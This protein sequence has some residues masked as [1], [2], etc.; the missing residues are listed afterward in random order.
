MASGG[1]DHC[2]KL[3]DIGR[4]ACVSTLRGQSDSVNAVHF[5]SFSNSLLSASADKTLSHWD[6]R[7]VCSPS[8]HLTSSA[9]SPHTNRDYVYRHILATRAPAMMSFLI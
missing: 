8:P 4:G 1:M 6:I 7:T 2:T 5:L 3:W 9:V